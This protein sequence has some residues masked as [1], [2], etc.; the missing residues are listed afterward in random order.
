M[1]END[2]H[3]HPFFAGA[4][5]TTEFKKLRKRIVRDVRQAIKQYG[6][7]ERDALACLFV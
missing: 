1:L 4:P 2:R 6:M 5:S 7:D 3:I